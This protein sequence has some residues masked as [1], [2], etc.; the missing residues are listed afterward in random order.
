[1]N[2]DKIFRIIIIIIILCSG[3]HAFGPEAPQE[4]CAGLRESFSLRNMSADASIALAMIAV[5]AGIWLVLYRVNA[6]ARKR[7]EAIAIKK[8][9]MRRQ[10]IS[11]PHPFRP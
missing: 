1:M 10:F 4:L 5:F 7:L 6:F 9:V 2:A 8:Q 11:W 3:V